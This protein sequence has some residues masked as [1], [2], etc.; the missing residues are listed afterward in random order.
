M[1]KF[2]TL[3]LIH[4]SLPVGRRRLLKQLFL[5]Y[6]RKRTVLS[7]LHFIT[8]ENVKGFRKFQLDDLK[9][10]KANRFCSVRLKGLKSKQVWLEDQLSI[11]LKSDKSSSEPKKACLLLASSIL[12]TDNHNKKE[13]ESRSLMCL[14]RIKSICIPK[15]LV[16][17]SL[18]SFP[19]SIS[20]S[21]KRLITKTNSIMPI[22]FA[23]F[24]G[25]EGDS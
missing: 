22:V 24:F 1:L 13:C 6:F 15:I 14:A 21:L 19:K 2:S 4:Q 17:L 16:R 5:K 25:Q 12:V 7:N 11:F 3:W 9:Q 18:N 8:Q 10:K 20:E 23:L